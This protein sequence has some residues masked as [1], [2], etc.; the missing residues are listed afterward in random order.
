MP[1][2]FPYWQTTLVQ[3][4]AD[5]TRTPGPSAHW[6]DTGWPAGDSAGIGLEVPVAAM[7]LAAYEFTS[8]VRRTAIASAFLLSREGRGI[9]VGYGRPG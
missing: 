6:G 9:L 4:A 7:R 3:T 5:C 2:N 8:V 1:R